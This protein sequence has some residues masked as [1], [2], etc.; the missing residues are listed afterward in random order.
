MIPNSYCKLCRYKT[1]R[2]AVVDD[3]TPQ[4]LD[5]R[6][7]SDG[8][9]WLTGRRDGDM[10]VAMLVADSADVPRN[11]AIRYTRHHCATNGGA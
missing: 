10:P 5:P 11:V 8:R 9:L 7:D 4:E 1:V 2:V 3:P 6:P